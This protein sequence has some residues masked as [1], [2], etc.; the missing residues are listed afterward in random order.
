MDGFLDILPFLIFLALV[1][2]NYISQRNKSNQ[3]Y[4]RIFRNVK[5]RSDG[6]IPAESWHDIDMNAAEEYLAEMKKKFPK[7]FAEVE[8]SIAEELSDDED[9]SDSDTEESDEFDE[10]DD[11]DESDDS[12]EYDEPEESAKPAI[13]ARAPLTKIPDFDE[14]LRKLR[15]SDEYR[16]PTPAAFAHSDPTDWAAAR[17]SEADGDYGVL[18]SCDCGER[19]ARAH[20]DVGFDSADDLKKAFVYKEI[21]SE[22]LALRERGE[23]KVW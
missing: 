7:E 4:E 5:R 21:I 1:V 14:R 20:F 2:A 12:D 17:D 8:D 3:K 22:P 11:S 10:Y 6:S 23:F 18:D 9:L 16:M 15:E 13:A 19:A